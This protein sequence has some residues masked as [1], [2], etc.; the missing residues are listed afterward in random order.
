MLSKQ[1]LCKVLLF[2][3]FGQYICYVKEPR[4]MFGWKSNML[5]FLFISYLIFIFGMYPSCVWIMW[6]SDSCPLLRSLICH[7]GCFKSSVYSKWIILTLIDVIKEH[8]RQTLYPYL[9]HCLPGF[10]HRREW[11]SITMDHKC[12][13][14][15][16][17]RAEKG[18]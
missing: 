13:Q 18:A 11:C 9:Q 16:G 1:K 2:N 6:N 8:S 10:L 15:F 3:F 12:R 5:I 4:E 14:I 17:Q 7:W